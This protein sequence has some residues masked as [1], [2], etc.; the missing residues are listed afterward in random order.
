MSNG[1]IAFGSEGISF[2]GSQGVNIQGSLRAG[3]IVSQT[4][5]DLVLRSIR[6]NLSITGRDSLLL[7]SIQG[8]IDV[9]AGEGNLTLNSTNGMVS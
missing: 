7:Q 8:P 1:S 3:Q 9:L 4:G 6:D 2:E 5:D